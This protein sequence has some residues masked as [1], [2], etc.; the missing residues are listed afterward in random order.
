[1]K[2]VILGAGVVGVTSAYYLAKAG[3][4]VTV[5]DRQPGPALETS[6]GN[7][8]EISPGYA[9]P[10][11]APGI[12]LKALRWLTMR[13]APLIIDPRLSVEMVR[14]VAQM[15]RNCT[16]ARYSL[17]KSRMVVLAEHSR[18]LL[19]DLRRELGIEYDHRSQGTLQLFS[20][21]RQL[22]G[23]AKDIEVLR[24]YGIPFE[25]LDHQGC[26]GAEPG[27]AYSQ[28]PFAGGLRLPH[29]ETGDCQK[30]TTAMADLLA[31]QGVTFRYNT[32]IDGLRMAGDRI[33][34][35]DT[36]AGP[37]AA[38]QILVALGSFSAGLLR[39]LGLRVPVYP[40]K[41]YSITLPIT[42]PDR[43]PV[44]TLLDENYKVAVTRLGDRIRVG[45]MAEL[46]GYSHTLP[47]RR[48]ETLLR[49]VTD[50]F[51]GAADLSETHFWSGLRPMT[52][53]GPPI[54]GPTRIPNL[55]LNTGHGTL[56][57]TMACGS[58]NLI[59]SLM[60]GRKPP[61]DPSGLALSRYHRNS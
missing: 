50:L 21:A 15:L 14:W 55:F 11:A 49:C 2:T 45:G 1:M 41:G 42:H 46:S 52:P 29:D 20:S 25:L 39:P 43:A 36:D 38:D 9:S 60:T 30:F 16:A 3:H 28:R 59:A 12:P 5:I 51:P 54:I 33:A 47:K 35:V 26:I 8:G 32:R 53:D 10:W 7:A 34:A 17:N 27:L 61:V 58:G 24:S 48:E 23:S 18:D 40:V 57:W 44:S 19:V 31:A 56:G 4:E 13:H 6:F 37:I 22:E